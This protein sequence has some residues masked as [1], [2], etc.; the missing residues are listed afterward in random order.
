MRQSGNLLQIPD[1]PPLPIEYICTEHC[2]VFYSKMVVGYTVYS[3]VKYE[4]I[5]Y[6]Q[7]KESGSG[8][9][10]MIWPDPT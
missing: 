9:I 4:I 8:R 6:S 3:R 10:L 1:L 2:I 7:F 5:S